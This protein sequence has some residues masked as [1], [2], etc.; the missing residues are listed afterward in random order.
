MWELKRS[1]ARTRKRKWARNCAGLKTPECLSTMQI[2]PNSDLIIPRRR[3][4]FP[5]EGAAHET[6]V[7]AALVHGTAN[8]CLLWELVP[9]FLGLENKNRGSDV[10]SQQV[11]VGTPQLHL[12]SFP[13]A[14]TKGH[15]NGWLLTADWATAAFTWSNQKFWNYSNVLVV[16]HPSDQ[17][18]FLEGSAN[19]SPNCLLQRHVSYPRVSLPS[20]TSIKAILH[21]PKL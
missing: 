10:P 16:G 9:Y 13:L 12:L 6:N 19:L 11:H 2:L 8:T 20:S 4:R 1:S 18:L 14:R 17:N 7:E 15:T 5:S 3:C 21:I